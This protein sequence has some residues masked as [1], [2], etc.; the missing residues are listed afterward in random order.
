MTE[1]PLAEIIGRTLAERG[2]TIAT[3][4][5]ITGGLLGATITGVPGA[6]RYYVGGVVVYAT[7]QKAR[8]GG[9]GAGVLKSHGVISEQTAVEMAMGVQ[10]LTGADYALAASG[11]AGPD[12]QEGHPPGVVWIAAAGP[13]VG[14]IEPSPVAL[15]FEFDGDRQQIREQTV[16]AALQ[17]LRKLLDP[18]EREHTGTGAR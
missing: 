1:R 16:S 17:M 7:E 11:V 8:I 9:V 3:S 13:R 10:E 6:S 18:A 4:E 5:S 15:R 2:L 12:P 14:A